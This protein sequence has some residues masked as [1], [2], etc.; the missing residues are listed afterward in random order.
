MGLYGAAVYLTSAVGR[1]SA[2]VLAE[3]SPAQR[4]PPERGG[5]RRKSAQPI[6]G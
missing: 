4:N 6:S 5:L 1:I 3:C 2:A